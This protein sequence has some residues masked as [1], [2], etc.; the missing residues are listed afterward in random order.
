MHKSLGVFPKSLSREAL[1]ATKQSTL[2]YEAKRIL[3]TACCAASGHVGVLMLLICP[4]VTREER[5]LP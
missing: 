4:C 1:Q 3:H 2:K 5:K